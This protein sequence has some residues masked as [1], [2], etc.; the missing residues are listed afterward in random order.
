MSDR[1]Y[2]VR[3]NVG[4]YTPWQRRDSTYAAIQ[5]AD[6]MTLWQHNVTI[7]TQTPTAPP[8]SG[9]WDRR[10][11][12]A[13]QVRFTEWAAPLGA[14]IWTFWPHPGQPEWATKA[15]KY[16]IMVPDWVDARA[17]AEAGPMFGRI[18]APT[19]R[20]A[21][22]LASRGGNNI[23]LCP[24]SPMLP[25]TLRVPTGPARVYV[26]PAAPEDDDVLAVD[27]I[28]AMFELDRRAQATISMDG[29]RG[30]IAKRLE[31]LAR[32]QPRLELARPE[33]YHRQVLRYGGHS[34]TLLSRAAEGF[35]MA[36]LCSLHMGTPVVGFAA[37]PLDEVAS[38]GN[39]LLV[40]P[41]ADRLD[42]LEGLMTLIEGAGLARLFAGCPAG[43]EQRRSEFEAAWAG[44]IPQMTGRR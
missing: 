17:L 21:R 12:H 9:F 2:G 40:A 28:D 6:L 42:L 29:R 39:S 8:V 33:D 25:V 38:P 13:T 43:L 3:M 32:A 11:R 4:I 18:M 14:V 41:R 23:V 16:T 24:W 7:L 26:P 22:T 30:A 35:G 19:R 37:P 20:C 15:G 34:L 31:R 1:P 10:V 27:I 5:I 36:A 44:A